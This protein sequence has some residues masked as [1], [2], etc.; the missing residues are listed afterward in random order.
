MKFEPL[1]ALANLK[2]LHKEDIDMTLYNEDSA[3]PTWNVTVA[4]IPTARIELRKQAAADEIRAVFCSED[5]AKDLMVHC[6]KTGFIQTMNKVKAEFWSNYTSNKKIATRFKQ[7]AKASFEN[8]RKRLLASYR[9]EYRN[10]INIVSA[11]M[12]K[13][14]YPDMGNALKE[15]LFANLRTVGLPEQ[16]AISVVEKSFAEGSAQYF[17]S[18]FEKAEEYMNLTPDS[19]KEIAAAISH[20]SH[21][22]HTASLHEVAPATLGDRV[23]QAS[24]VANTFNGAPSMRVSNDVVID[25]NAY[26]AQLRS[27]WRNR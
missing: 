21:L 15:N 6:E 3:N 11:G 5:Y 13:N 23:A 27:V 14:F 1:A 4:G 2:D 19:R 25:S 24:T 9:Q 26:K 22:E 7:E 10:C 16:T 12:S 8:E 17:E 18:L 20:G